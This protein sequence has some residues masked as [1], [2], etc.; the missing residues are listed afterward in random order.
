MIEFKRIPLDLLD[1]NTGQ[2]PG[3]PK[4]P[5]KWSRRELENLAASMRDTP[6][7]TEARGAIVYPFQGRFVVLGGNMRLEGHRIN[8]DKDAP[9]AILPEDTPAD[10]LRQIVQKDNASFG[11][12]DYDILRKE[13]LDFGYDYKSWGLHFDTKELEIEEEAKDDNFDVDRAAAAIKTPKTQKGDIWQLGDHFLMCGDSTSA[14]DVARLMDGTRADLSVTDPPYNVAYEGGTQDHLTI[15]NDQMSD[16]AFHDF[17]LAAF[18]R[19][20]EALKPGAANYVFFA[21]KEARNFIDAYIQ[22]GFLYKQ[23]LIWV[24]NT[25]TLT[26][27]DYQWQHEPCIYGW[28]DGAPHYFTDDRTLRTVVDEWPDFDQMDKAAL[29]D[30]CKRVFDKDALATDIVREDKPTRNAEHPT[31]KPIP[32]VGRFVRNSSQRGQSVIDLFGGS[33]STLMACEQLKR[34]CRTMEYDP[35]Y[36]DVII[37]RWEK[38]TGRKATKIE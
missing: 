19:M 2:I 18:T 21:C 26:R 3:V 17:L 24:K 28:K 14:E 4:N 6:E 9:C 13:W 30:F 35:V 11:Q 29:R 25:I 33:G 12:F 37:A 22:A 32:L 23:L 15:K 7:L 10:K 20:N 36:C 8:E 31:M 27:S 38:Y 5:R 1:P 34:Q 16:G